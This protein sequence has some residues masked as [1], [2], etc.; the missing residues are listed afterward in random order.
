MQV[1]EGCKVIGKEED[2][3]KP[4]MKE[5]SNTDTSSKSTENET[6][7]SSEDYKKEEEMSGKEVSINV[8][9]SK[10]IISSFFQ[11]KLSLSIISISVS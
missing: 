7:E 3:G 11:F 1:Y 10:K 2:T 8:S 5:H 9:G 6:T 4:L